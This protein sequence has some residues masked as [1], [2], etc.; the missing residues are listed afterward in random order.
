MNRIL[1]SCVLLTGLI[2]G[3]AQAAPLQVA[4]ADIPPVA[5][6]E[7]ALGP[8]DAPVT[9]VEY[10]S[11][12][13]PHCAKW[14]GEV[15]PQVRKEWI[16]TGKI[17]FVFRDYPLDGLALKA[18]Q[19][20]RCTGDQRFWGFIQTMFSTQ[21]GWARSKDPIPE[22]IKIGKLGAVSEDKAKEC[23]ADDNAMAKS[24][25][26]SRQAAEAAGV[27]GTPAFFLNGKL[28]SNIELP[29]DEL[30]KDLQQAGVK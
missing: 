26:A 5:A 20:A 4:S 18:S 22:L 3:I 8:A 12:T 2:A 17:R 6:D 29:Y 1:L 25:V 9:I 23:M 14:E 19:L 24:I 15:F 30:V 11:M 7:M 16:D 13:C 21:L 28:I 10:A 27:N